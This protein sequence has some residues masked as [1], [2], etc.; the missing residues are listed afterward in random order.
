[1]KTTVT[2]KAKAKINLTLDVLAVREDGYHD[3]KSVMQTVELC[4]QVTLTKTEEDGIK[5]TANVDTVPLDESNTVVAAVRAFEEKT[6]A[7]VGGLS[8]HLE[9]N[10]PVAAGIGGGSV[11][12]W[13]GDAGSGKNITI[14]GGTVNA[15]GTD[16]GAGIGGGENGNGEDITINGGKVNASGA[17]GGAG[18]GGGVNGIGSKVTVSGAAQVTAT[19]T[20]SGPDWS[21]VGTG[22]TIGNGG[23]KTPDGP[24][25]GK[26]IQ[27]DIS[28]L[29]TGYI[30]HIIYEQDGTT[31]KRE[32][33]EP[34][35]PQPNPEDPNAPTE[36]SNEVD[37]GTPGLHV[38]TLEGDPLPFDARQ[39]GS[40]LRV[41]SNTLAARLHG[42]R[43]ALEA[44][45]EQG[46]EQIQFVTTLKTTTL[47]VEDLLAEGGSWFALEHNGLA[48]R[49]LSAAQAESLKCWMH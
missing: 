38:E 46:V 29:T 34:V 10:I 40:T 17:Y 49:R 5:V 36:E 19:A 18:I 1:M 41:T 31:I 47:S 25:D 6:G 43:Q 22:A 48:S 16:G 35:R 4:D 9:K 32:W 15:T 30:H 21:G 45:R 27:A 13:G 26:E 7:A 44:L 2:E 8:I 42:T 12:A 3:I 28:H 20:G 37:L 39:Q 33:W 23:S 11:G 24:V 14:N